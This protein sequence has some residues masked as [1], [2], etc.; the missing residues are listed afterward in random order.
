MINSISAL[1]VLPTTRPI[2]FRRSMDGL[3]MLVREQLGADPRD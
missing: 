1:R 2:E 3:A